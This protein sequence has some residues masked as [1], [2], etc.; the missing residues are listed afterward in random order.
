MTVIVTNNHCLEFVRLLKSMDIGV[1]FEI[2][3]INTL[4][5]ANE[6][7]LT[8]YA[9]IAQNESENISANVSGAGK[10]A[11]SKARSTSAVRVFGLPQG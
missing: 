7:M 3:G 1:L 4:K 6:M 2:Q 5:M 11:S 9:G 10:G 8:M